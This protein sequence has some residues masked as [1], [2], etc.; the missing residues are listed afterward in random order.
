MYQDD[1]L[2]AV[3]EMARRNKDSTEKL[4][5]LS[6][7]IV[8]AKS[9]WQSRQE[10]NSVSGGRI[11]KPITKIV[12]QPELRMVLMFQGIPNWIFLVIVVKMTL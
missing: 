2:R 4:E 1:K 7:E 8:V 11:D 6:Q 12:V 5:S 10:D 9:A 3:E